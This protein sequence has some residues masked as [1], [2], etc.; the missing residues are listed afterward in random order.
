MPAG[1]VAVTTF[2]QSHAP[3]ASMLGE[4]AMVREPFTSAESEHLSWL[5]ELDRRGMEQALGLRADD[6]EHAAHEA[7]EQ[8]RYELAEAR[9]AQAGLVSVSTTEKRS[10]RRAASPSQQAQVMECRTA[11]RAAVADLLMPDP[12]RQ[13]LGKL[14]RAVGFSA[15]CHGVAR[16]GH[17]PDDVLMITLTYAKGGDWRPDHVKSLLTHVRKWL[18]RRSLRC[19]YTWVAELQARGVIHYHIALWVPVGVRLPKPDEQGWW[20]YGS[21]RI[22]VARSAPRYLMK[23]LSKPKTGVGNWRLPEGARMYGVGGL[24]HSLRRARRWLGLPV[25]VQSYSDIFDDWRRAPG[26]GWCDPDGEVFRSEFKVAR[27]GSQ[28]A[29]ERVCTHH[30]GSVISGASVEPSGPFSWLHRGNA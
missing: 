22:E 21:T 6:R 1:V 25:W 24:D 18:Q 29:L 30:R 7:W 5:D 20:P 23:Y 26:G 12:D 10:L 11:K 16:Q 19:R 15:R 3:K 28:F 4:Y 14:R 2:Q 27:C 8:V 17:R 13:R 9:S